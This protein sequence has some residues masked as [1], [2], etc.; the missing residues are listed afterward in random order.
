MVSLAD[1]R[2]HITV[3]DLIFTR[4]AGQCLLMDATMQKLQDSPLPACPS[5]WFP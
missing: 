3:A 5:N 2:G 1:W 4:C